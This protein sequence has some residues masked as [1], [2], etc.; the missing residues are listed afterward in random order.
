MPMKIIINLALN[1]LAWKYAIENGGPDL[2]NVH[3]AV[4]EETLSHACVDI[5]FL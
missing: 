4:N 2:L 1:S 3:Q 5:F